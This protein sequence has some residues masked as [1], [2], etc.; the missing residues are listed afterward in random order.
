VNISLLPVEQVLQG[1]NAT[2]VFLVADMPP[3]RADD[4]RRVGG[5]LAS[6]LHAF[7]FFTKIKVAALVD[8]RIN[9][10]WTKS[11][12]DGPGAPSELSLTITSKHPAP[13]VFVDP[14]MLLG[15]FDDNGFLLLPNQP[16]TV[17]FD[18]MGEAVTLEDLQRE[19]RVRTPWHAARSRQWAH[20]GASAA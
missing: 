3:S 16:R 8:P 19:V 17:V 1:H 18:T 15:H 6:A 13:F 2:Q 9:V 7:Y 20:Q 12:G 14:G 11:S 10:T 5:P 4:A